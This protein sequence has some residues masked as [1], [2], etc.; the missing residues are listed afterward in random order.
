M[1]V[2]S[3]SLFPSVPLLLDPEGLFSFVK[4]KCG[5]FF[6][7]TSKI[8]CLVFFCDFLMAHIFETDQ[9]L[10]RA[11]ETLCDFA[12]PEQTSAYFVT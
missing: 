6:A 1:K 2:F 4:E 11:A 10:P 5:F 8:L 3:L 7:S 12:V 9:R